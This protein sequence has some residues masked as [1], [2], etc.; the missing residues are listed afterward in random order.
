MSDTAKKL[1]DSLKAAAMA[2]QSM[3]PGLQNAGA[4]IK[5]EMSRLGT[6]GAMEL[7]SALFAGHAFVPYG[8]GQQTPHAEHQ[9]HEHVNEVELG[10]ERESH[11][12][13]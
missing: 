11:G 7:A 3:A 9:P 10:R 12:R 13:E 1:F 6:Q 2:A 5:G 8:P 4:E